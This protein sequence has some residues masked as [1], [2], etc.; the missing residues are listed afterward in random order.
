MGAWYSR[1]YAYIRNTITLD[2]IANMPYD[3]KKDPPT[4]LA[5]AI[6]VM[7]IWMYNTVQQRKAQYST[8]Q[9]NTLL[10]NST[11]LLGRMLFPAHIANHPASNGSTDG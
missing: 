5:V 3:V 7:C 10:G 4:R 6:P 11:Q 8:I 9:Y 2:R 1:R